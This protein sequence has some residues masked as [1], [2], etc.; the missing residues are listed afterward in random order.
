[1]TPPGTLVRPSRF[2]PR[3]HWELLVCGV[4]GHE[5]VGADAARLRPEDALYAREQEGLRWYRCLRCDSWLPLPPP[6]A[7][8]R[9]TPPARDE[10]EL[11]LRGKA[12]RDRVVLR[13]IAIDRAIH[14]VVLALLAVAVFLFASHEV[15]LRD[16][17]Y[18]VVNAVQGTAGGPTHTARGGFL[19][20]L[21]HVFTLKSSTLYAVA[22]A[23]AA[24][25]VLEGVEAVGLWY[26]RR[27]AEYLTF[28]ATCAF[29]PYEVWELTR[30]VSPF[31][32]VAI[33][34]NV[35]IAVYLL[36]AKRLFGLRGGGA[37]DEA[38]RARDVG[39]EALERTAPTPPGGGG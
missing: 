29:L 33:V 20:S 17:F 27:W 38:E 23:A 22:V 15:R 36:L 1:M 4:R 26:Q 12:L 13:V 3:F 25:A 35:A 32:V 6:A 2:R 16:V 34:V 7:P 19:G 5:L 9:E 8:D 30:T 21:E 18:R 11:P 14:F 24:Y 39:W 28:V 37:A 10:I 31:K